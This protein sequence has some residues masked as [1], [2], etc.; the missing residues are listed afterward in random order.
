MNWFLPL[1]RAITETINLRAGLP[2]PYA[3]SS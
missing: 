3:R 2:R 1:G